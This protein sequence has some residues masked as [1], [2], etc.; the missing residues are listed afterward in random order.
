M[1]EFTDD[2]ALREVG[3]G[4]LTATPTDRWNIVDTPNGGYLM[5]IVLN[6]VDWV[7]PHPDPL[8]VT[9]HFLART[10]PNQEATVTVE[11][12]R[13]GRTFSTA[14][15]AFAQD[16]REKIRALATF[17]DLRAATG[18]SHIDATPPPVPPLDQCSPVQARADHFSIVD[19]LDTWVIP[20]MEPMFD[21]R[22]GGPAEL[23]GWIRFRDGEEPN[24]RSL[25]FFADALPPPI[26]NVLPMTW[27][28]TV[29]MTVHFRGHPA[30]GPLRFW[31]RSRFL[32]GGF[33]E[34]DGELWDSAGNLVALSRQ[35]AMVR[36]P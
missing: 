12:L 27:V 32:V 4:R 15:A 1:S 6:A 31:F 16:D 17:G 23:G 25:V 5:A 20:G 24:I 19:R 7:L 36:N 33:L 34:E 35:F 30:P 13:A 29:E 21:M 28:P 10:E 8:T 22:Q 9:A 18:P 26:I 3:P 14:S 11:A 2:T